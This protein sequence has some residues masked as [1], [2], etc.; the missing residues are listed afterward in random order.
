M[1]RKTENFYCDLL[2]SEMTEAFTND[3]GKAI[4]RLPNQ[5]RGEVHDDV[6]VYFSALAMD[7]VNSIASKYGINDPDAL[8][9]MFQLTRLNLV[10]GF[11]IG[12]SMKGSWRPS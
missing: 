4:L 5:G 1:A 2:T 8:H 9:E 11:R 10:Q 6:V 3:F 7:Q 12:Q